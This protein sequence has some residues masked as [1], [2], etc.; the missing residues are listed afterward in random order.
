VQKSA[1]EDEPKEE[2]VGLEQN[3]KVIVLI[4]IRPKHVIR[5]GGKNKKSGPLLILQRRESQQGCTRGYSERIKQKLAG[6][7]SNIS[8]LTG[9]GGNAHFG[10]EKRGVI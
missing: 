6:V 9:I 1:G 8:E 10:G 4:H 7:G 2:V 3:W 5:P